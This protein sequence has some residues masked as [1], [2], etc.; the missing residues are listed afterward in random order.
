MEKNTSHRCNFTHSARQKIFKTP[1]ILY[2]IYKLQFRKLK[3]S[4]SERHL[5]LIIKYLHSKGGWIGK[6]AKK[7][8]NFAR[9]AVRRRPKSAR[10]PSPLPAAI[11]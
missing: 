1:I 11:R 2:I 10:G 7:I 5:L 4:F 6:N 3:R 8:K 9:E